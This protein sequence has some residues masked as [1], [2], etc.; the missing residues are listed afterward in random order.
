MVMVMV[1]VMVVVM[2]VVVVVDY[3]IAELYIVTSLQL[4]LHNTQLVA[5]SSP[6]RPVRS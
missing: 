4:L 3:F 2:V 5:R 1:M 6:R